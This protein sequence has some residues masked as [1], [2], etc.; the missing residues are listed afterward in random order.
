MVDMFA[1]GLITR[2]QVNIP[3]NEV[4]S[5]SVQTIYTTIF[6]VAGGVAVIIIILAGIR[7]ITSQGDS[8]ATAKARNT[9]IYAAIGLAVSVT[10]F[11]FVTFV[12]GRL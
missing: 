7:F 3:T 8:Q 11:S 9:I 10:A 12:A 4:N 5:N 6:V 2:D 1:R